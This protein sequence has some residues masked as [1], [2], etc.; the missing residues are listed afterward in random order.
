MQWCYFLRDGCIAG[1]QMLPSGLPDEDKIARA[2]ILFSKREGQFDGFENWDGGRVEF[3][4]PDPA[5][6][7]GMVSVA[8]YELASASRRMTSL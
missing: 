8:R 6:K 5:K 7:P 2:H 1:V 3:S 4:Y